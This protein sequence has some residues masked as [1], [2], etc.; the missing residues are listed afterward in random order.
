MDL[1]CG[2]A[3]GFQP[4]FAFYIKTSHLICSS[5]RKKGRSPVNDRM[6]VSYD[7][8]KF[9]IADHSDYESYDTA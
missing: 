5:A 7:Q 4:S 6:K 8:I 1:K 2:F 3:Y 9:S